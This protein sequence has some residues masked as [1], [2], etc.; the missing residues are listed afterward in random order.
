[1]QKHCAYIIISLYPEWYLSIMV[2]AIA[3][4]Y[5]LW[6]SIKNTHTH[7]LSLSKLTQRKIWNIYAYP[8]LNRLWP[9]GR[10]SYC[11]QSWHKHTCQW[12]LEIHTFYFT[13]KYNDD[14]SHDY[15]CIIV[16]VSTKQK[17]AIGL[18]IRTHALRTH[19][20]N[21][22]SLIL[23]AIIWTEISMQGEAL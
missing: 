4:L 8:Y 17:F 13:F 3:P 15:S 23:V 10:V 11:S 6:T 7:S 19:S 22:Y 21:K 18:C 14:I 16:K 9:S 12:H 5:V 1:M 2:Y 20:C